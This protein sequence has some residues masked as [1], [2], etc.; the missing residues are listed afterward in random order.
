MIDRRRIASPAG[1]STS[2]PSLSGPRCTSAAF[3][4]SSAAGSGLDAPSSETMP[5]MPHMSGGGR[6]GAA[7]HGGE[8]LAERP[9][10]RLRE[11]ARVE[12][13]GAVGDVLE[14][15]RE[16]LRPRVL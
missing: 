9:P 3:M 11:H 7:A 12:V 8:R 16:L 10:R 4:C 14:V 6:G 2:T 13:D 5:Q 1:P 15:V